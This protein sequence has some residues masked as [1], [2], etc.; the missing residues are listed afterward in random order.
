[1]TDQPAGTPPPR[2]RKGARS[3]RLSLTDPVL[4]AFWRDRHLQTLTTLTP[5]GRPHSVP[6][7]AVLSVEDEV[8]RILCSRKSRKARNVR[9]A[10]PQPAFVTVCQVEGRWWTT[11]EGTAELQEDRL[12][13]ADAERR[14]AGRF[15]VPRPNPERVVLVV[16]VESVLGSLPEGEAG[17]GPV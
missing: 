16:H 8:V 17:L 15:R 12:L 5:Q 4:Q 10:Y 6:V 14:Y 3:H 11:I 7:A 13:V 1:M 2:V 9:A